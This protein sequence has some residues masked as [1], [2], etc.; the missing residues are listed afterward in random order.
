[1][2][3]AGDF[4][5]PLGAVLRRAPVHASAFTEDDIKAYKT[6]PWRSQGADGGAQLLPCSLSTYSSE[7]GI[8]AELACR[9][10]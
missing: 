5:L 2:F 9:R 10:W 6:A 8:Q 7:A 4:A 3:R 1:M